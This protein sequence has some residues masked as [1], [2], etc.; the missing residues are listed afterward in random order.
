M[1][2]QF[3]GK[4]VSSGK[5]F[6]IIA[7]RFNEFITKGL[8]D[9]CLDT[10]KRHGAKEQDADVYWVPGAYEIPTLA[11]LLAKKKK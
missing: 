5:K 2:K 1:Q 6:A 8:L 7:A 4:L 3:S 10:L 11:H 9:G